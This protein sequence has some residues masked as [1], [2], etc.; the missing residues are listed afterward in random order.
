MSKVYRI[1]DHEILCK[2]IAGGL[3]MEEAAAAVEFHPT[4]VYRVMR[5]DPELRARYDR[6]LETKGELRADKIRARIEKRALDDGD[7]KSAELLRKA[8]DL[9]LEEARKGL[10]ARIELAPVELPEI[11]GRRAVSIADVAEL[12]AQLGIRIAIG[13]DGG[14]ARRALPAATDVLP[15]P[16][17]D[18]DA[19]SGLPHSSD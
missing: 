6:A 17:A 11:E 13:V 15:D 19:A 1:S 10:D 4:T 7:P 12:A 2:H 14:D 16:A 5:D 3:S 9:W 8:A 18:L